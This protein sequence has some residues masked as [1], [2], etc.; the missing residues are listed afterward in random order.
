MF[1]GGKMALATCA[2]LNCVWVQIVHAYS[3]T[4]SEY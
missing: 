2:S 4:S 1:V 3:H